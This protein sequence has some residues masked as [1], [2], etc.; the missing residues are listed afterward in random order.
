MTTEKR[1]EDTGLEPVIEQPTPEPEQPA[2]EQ[3]KPEKVS[4]RVDLP[5]E[6]NE[7]LRSL[8]ALWGETKT[9]T[10]LKLLTGAV[11]HHYSI[12]RMRGRL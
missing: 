10:A 9:Q 12:N 1:N 5:V 3:P 8:A 6:T 11:Q 7:N 4:V 2:P